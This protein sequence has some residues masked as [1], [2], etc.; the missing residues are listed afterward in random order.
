MTVPAKKVVSFRPGTEM[1]ERVRRLSAKT[2]SEVREEGLRREQNP[3]DESDNDAP[4]G[5]KS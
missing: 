5:I 1:E 4:G 3:H 2:L